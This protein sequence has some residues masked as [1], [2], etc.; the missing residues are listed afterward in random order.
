MTSIL[1]LA[2]YIIPFYD[3]TLWPLLWLTPALLFHAFFAE[4]LSAISL[5][6]GSIFA[7]ALHLLPLCQALIAMA[8]TDAWIKYMPPALLICYVSSYFALFLLASSSQLGRFY[9][10]KAL[11]V[12][13]VTLWLFLLFLEYTML[14]PFGRVEGY[15]FLNPLLPM[16]LWPHTIAP[17]YFLSMPIVLLWYCTISSAAYL[18]WR[19]GTIREILLLVLLIIPWI[20][21]GACLKKEAAPDWLDRV[22][23][24][25]LSLP[26]SIDSDRGHLLLRFELD[27]LF[28]QH[29]NISAI[30]MPESSWNGT[31]LSD[32]HS[33]DWLKNHPIQHIVIGSFALKSGSLI[34][35]LYWFENGW[36]RQQCDKHHALPLVERPTLG[37]DA[38]CAS[39]YFPDT[40]AVCAAEQKRTPLCIPGL[41]PLMP[42]ICSD[43]YC[44]NWPDAPSDLI[45]ASSNDGWFM[46]HFQKL[47]ALAARLRGA[48]WKTSVLYISF[49][50]A[51]Y[52]DQCGTGHKIATSPPGRL[53]A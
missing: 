42:Y 49:H 45:L 48:Q 44:R 47:M 21:M 52:F 40:P 10:P 36:L 5:I 41:P 38:L 2:C 3:T 46:P 35:C 15:L 27:F 37:A 32:K 13:T 19:T 34:N 33:L 53:I 4:K 51:Q 14:W 28:D 31:A 12:W 30:F 18:A 29:P 16:A 8:Q 24:L 25:P 39:L 9:L 1:A 26:A 7:V 22:G 43:L 50:Y 6:V 17:L 20:G 11:F 23:H